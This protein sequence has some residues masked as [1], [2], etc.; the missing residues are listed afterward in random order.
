MKRKSVR[1]CNS[2]K[3]FFRAYHFTEIKIL[4]GIHSAIAS[5]EEVIRLQFLAFGNDFLFAIQAMLWSR[6]VFVRLPGTSPQTTD[7]PAVS[8]LPNLV[9]GHVNPCPRCQIISPDVIVISA[10]AAQFVFIANGRFDLKKVVAIPCEFYSEM[11]LDDHLVVFVFIYLDDIVDD[12][13]QLNTR[14]VHFHAQLLTKV[15]L[16]VSHLKRDSFRPA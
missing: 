3:A 10:K 7:T 2:D 1:I 4:V 15:D 6:R 16:Y 9:L 13:R 12:V 5:S 8:E 14:S 11:R